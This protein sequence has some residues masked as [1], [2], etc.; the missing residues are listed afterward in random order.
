M[1]KEKIGEFVCYRN[2]K[3]EVEMV[4]KSEPGAPEL[5]EEQKATNKLICDGFALLVN[6]YDGDFDKATK[7]IISQ[8]EAEEKKLQEQVKSLKAGCENE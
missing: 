3:G 5:T 2:A 6:N 1:K 7:D 4:Y 8:L